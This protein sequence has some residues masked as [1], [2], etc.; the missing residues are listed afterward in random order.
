MHAN[1]MVTI[2]EAMKLEPPDHAE[3]PDHI[4]NTTVAK[5]L[6]PVEE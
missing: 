6:V 5:L 3:A 4:G 1:E 2:L